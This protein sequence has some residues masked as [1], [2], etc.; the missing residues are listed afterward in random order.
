MVN[1]STLLYAFPETLVQG[2]YYEFSYYYHIAQGN[3]VKDT[4]IQYKFSGGQYV[5]GINLYHGPKEYTRAT[6]TFQYTDRTD[7][8]VLVLFMVGIDNQYTDSQEVVVFDN[9]SVVDAPAPAA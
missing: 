5:G 8:T 7:Q 6:A 4:Y 9:F 2:N 3:S 1:V